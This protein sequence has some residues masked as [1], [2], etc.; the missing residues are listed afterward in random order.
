LEKW[1]YLFEEGRDDK[2]LLG[3]KGVG[4]C[5]MTQAGFPIPP[6]LIVTTQ[7]AFPITRMKGN[8]QKACGTRSRGR[9]KKLKRVPCRVSG[10]AVA[11][12]VA[13]MV[14]VTLSNWMASVGPIIPDK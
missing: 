5:E 11:G 14:M 8:S 2:S 10:K 13:G 4:L 9:W 12:S 6:G 7:P 3:S 1:V